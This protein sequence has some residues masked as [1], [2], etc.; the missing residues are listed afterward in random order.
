MNQ[1]QALARSGAQLRPTILTDQPLWAAP[2]ESPCSIEHR[3]VDPDVVAATL[4]RLL[5]LPPDEP[6][7][8]ELAARFGEPVPP[9][10]T[11]LDAGAWI[12]WC[13]AGLPLF[14]GGLSTGMP[15]LGRACCTAKCLVLA[16]AM[17]RTGGNLSGVHRLTGTSRKIIRDNLRRLGLYPWPA[18]LCRVLGLGG[19]L[20]EVGR[21]R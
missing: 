13:M 18:A 20:G 11:E 21:A 4:R 1:I 12:A 8:G 3:D 14:G 10:V 7:P 17:L 5:G 19:R 15:S 16:L 2:S 9:R 6:A